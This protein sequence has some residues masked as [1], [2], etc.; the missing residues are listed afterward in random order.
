MANKRR[1]RWQHEEKRKEQYW[2]AVWSSQASS[3]DNRELSSSQIRLAL[4]RLARLAY[5]GESNAN[6]EQALFA[7]PTEGEKA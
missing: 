5:N 6:I 7:E 3:A 1:Q 4:L 2:A